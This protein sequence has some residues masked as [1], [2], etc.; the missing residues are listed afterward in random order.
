MSISP[1]SPI[2]WVILT[3]GGREEQLAAAIESV[4]QPLGS[5]VVVSNGSGELPAVEAAGITVVVSPE[6]LGVPGG[7][8]LGITRIGD[9]SHIVG[10][11]DDDAVAPSG[12]ADR[13]VEE[14]T[15]DE[16]LGAVSLRLID[17]RGR[18]ARRHVPWPGGRDAERSGET[19]L[20]LGGACA[21]RREAYEDVGGYFTELFYGHEEVE[22]CWRLVDRGWTI[23]YL[24]NIEVFHPRTMIERHPN[25][26]ELTGRNRVWIARR[27]LPWPLA[28][29]HVMTWLVLGVWRAP[30][31]ESRR[32]YLS[33]W[34]A[35]WS[36]NVD[37]RPIRWRTVWRLT[38]LGRPPI[39]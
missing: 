17:E 22:L 36:T 35:G 2:S 23:R 32:R 31:G 19:A 21:L 39:L 16:R 26:W 6:N 9:H 1:A 15:A 7:R 24:A 25:G 8:D 14:F 37:H 29:V 38:L 3:T 33:G 20:F 34:R 30:K 10:F 13:I 11:L 5:V 12:V 18:T 4:A 28:F 27:S